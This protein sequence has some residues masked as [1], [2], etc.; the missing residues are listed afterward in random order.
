MLLNVDGTPKNPVLAYAWID[1]AAERGYP[2]FVATRVELEAQLTA[3]QLR[4]A[5]ALR[6][7]LAERYADAV[8]KPR[9]AL[10]LRWGQ[11]QFTGSPTGFDSGVTQISSSHCGPALIIGGR[12]GANRLRCLQSVPAEGQLAAGPVFRGG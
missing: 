2:G 7:S 5:T 8:A 4:E 12:R 9:M 11:M 10:E 3:A 1:L 6:A